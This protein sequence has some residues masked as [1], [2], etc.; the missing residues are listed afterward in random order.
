MKSLHVGS[1]MVDTIALIATEDIERLTL[2]NEDV[3]FLMVETGR[4]LPAESITTHVGGG[5]CNTAVSLR[6]RGWDSV[7]AAKVGRDLNAEAVREHLAGHGVGSH[8]T[9]C[10]QATGSA[11]MVAS[12]DRNASILVHRGA[13][14]LLSVAD[15]P[16]LVGFDL[17][18]LAPLSSGSADGFPEIARRA[19]S[20][21]ARVAA[22]PG[23]RQLRSRTDEFLS[24]LP[25]VDLLSINRS[26]A[27]A[28]VPAVLRAAAADPASPPP[29]DPPPLV[30]RGLR[31]GG[32]EIGLPRFMR[33]LRS[34][35]PRWLAVT[36]G[37][38]GSYLGCEDGLFWQAT[39]PTAVAGTAGAGDAFCSTL[40]AALIEGLSPP[41]ALL[42][43]AMNAAAVV[44]AVD[45]TSGLL[46][47]EQMR[48]RLAAGQ[49]PQARRIG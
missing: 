44:G 15:L 33:A 39:L 30:R 20:A 12:H 42:Q 23:I 2:S 32:W 34:F 6:R 45:T 3:S 5:A 21:G 19:H 9:A 48:L 49:D 29:S 35:G 8:L 17:V 13:N 37:S 11:V 25:H 18:Y 40:T 14:E 31:T 27:D 16:D 26:E 46:G 38:G 41:E 28:L 22:N 43:A 7:V 1:A 10:G 24:A 4:K 36:D 47:A